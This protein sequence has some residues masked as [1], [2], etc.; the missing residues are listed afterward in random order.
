MPFNHKLAFWDMLFILY[1]RSLFYNNESYS[2]RG[3]GSTRNIPYL[4]GTMWS[5][6]QLLRKWGENKML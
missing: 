2:G 4:F 3:R 6:Q 5:Q 1:R